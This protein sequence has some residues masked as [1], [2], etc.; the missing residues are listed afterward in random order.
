MNGRGFVLTVVSTPDGNGGKGGRALSQCPLRISDN[1]RAASDYG[2]SMGHHAS[3]KGLEVRMADGAAFGVQTIHHREQDWRSRCNRTLRVTRSDRKRHP[4]V[5]EDQAG[6]TAEL[7]I[8]G[9]CVALKQR[10]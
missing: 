5:E 6:R 10:R 4:D 9:V 2:F 8:D 3:S 1:P 7:W